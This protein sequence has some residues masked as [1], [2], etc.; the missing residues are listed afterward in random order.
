MLRAVWVADHEGGLVVYGPFFGTMVDIDVLF[1]LEKTSTDAL[2]S[3]SLVAFLIPSASEQSVLI[4]ILN[5]S[6][7]FKNCDRTIQVRPADHQHAVSTTQSS[8]NRSKTLHKER[9]NLIMLS[10]L[11]SVKVITYI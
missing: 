9:R 8:S 11:S 4:S 5:L 3:L 6:E 2:L 7:A 1:S 10:G